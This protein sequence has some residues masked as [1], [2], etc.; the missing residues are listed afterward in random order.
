MQA[1]RNAEACSRWF[2]IVLGGY[3]RLAA[4]SLCGPCLTRSAPLSGAAD[5]IA[6]AHSAGP[7]ASDRG[8]LAKK[9]SARKSDQ[10]G[11]NIAP[12]WLQNCPQMT[13]IWLPNGPWKPLGGFLEVSR[14]P[15]GGLLEA[16][17]PLRGVSIAP[18]ALGERS[19]SHLGTLLSPNCF[20][21]AP[22]L[23]SLFGIH[24]EIAL[25]IRVFYCLESIS[26]TMLDTCFKGFEVHARTSH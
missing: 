12:T 19:W 23:G 3:R 15:L 2:T 10:H 16:W 6:H 21:V 13:P 14:E 17:E 7:G 11:G 22:L 1:R 5:L 25:K 8:P 24:F 9:P 26:G 20:H 4:G 18:G